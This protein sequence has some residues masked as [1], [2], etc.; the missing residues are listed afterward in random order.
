MIKITCVVENEALPGT[1]FKAKHG[2]AWL[3][4]TGSARVLF[5]T[6]PDPDLLAHNAALLA[7]DWATI[8]AVVLSHAHLDHT[9]GLPAVIA[10]TRSSI[11]LYAHPD[12]FRERY[13]R[14]ARCG[15]GI[16]Q[17]VLDDHFHLRLDDQ[18][19]EMVN[20][21]WTTGEIVERKFFEG[22]SKWHEV[23]IDGEWIP[24]PYRD[25]FSVVVKT[26]EGLVVLC[27]CCHA[28]LLNTLSQ[29]SRTFDG[30]IITVAG[31]THLGSADA[32]MLAKAVDALRDDYNQP[33]LYP[34]H[35]TGQKAFNVL[36]DAFGEKVQPC[37][38]G[39]VLTF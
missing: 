2:I 25:D 6:G 39:T 11:P 31:G 13:S 1:S 36:A 18:P 22:R 24:D 3:I 32:A 15:M 30:K 37:P 21:V 7:L 14:R 12:I 9:G 26:G 33:R 23:Q 8:D 20:E 4:D 17:K 5:D 16:G 19:V 34:S 28:G 27:G 29:I 38:A 10:H 35:C